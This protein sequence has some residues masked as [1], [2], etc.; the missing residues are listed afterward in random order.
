MTNYLDYGK[1]DVRRNCPLGD[2]VMTPYERHEVEKAANEYYRWAR[3][4]GEIP[5][6]RSKRKPKWERVKDAQ[7]EC[8]RINAERDTRRARGENPDG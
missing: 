5:V 2:K 6:C 1:M 4:F 7:A 3:F 8:D